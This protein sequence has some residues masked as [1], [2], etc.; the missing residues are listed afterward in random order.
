MSNGKNRR[1]LSL[2]SVRNLTLSYEKRKSPSGYES[3]SSTQNPKRSSIFQKLVT[4]RKSSR[5]ASVAGNEITK[6]S[7]EPNSLLVHKVTGRTSQL[8]LKKPTNGLSREEKTLILECIEFLDNE[9]HALEVE[10]IFRSSGSFSQMQKLRSRLKQGYKIPRSSQQNQEDAPDPL[11]VAD[12][13][14]DL[15]RNSESPLLPKET[16]QLLLS[17]EQSNT[18]L[19]LL[20]AVDEMKVNNKEV[21]EK[22]IQLLAKTSSL[23]LFNHMSSKNIATIFTPTLIRWDP[24]QPTA[25]KELQAVTEAITSII[26]DSNRG[27]SMTEQTKFK[28]RQHHSMPL[29]LQPNPFYNPPKYLFVSKRSNDDTENC[30]DIANDLRS[31]PKIKGSRRPKDIPQWKPL[32]EEERT[33]FDASFHAVDV[34]DR[35][36]I[37]ASEGIKFFSKFNLSLEQVALIWNLVDREESG[38]LGIRE[39]RVAMALCMGLNRNCQIPTKLPTVL[40][41]ELVEPHRDSQDYDP[42]ITYEKSQNNTPFSK[43]LFGNYHKT[44]QFVKKDAQ[45]IESNE[46]CLKGDNSVNSETLE[47]EERHDVQERIHSKFV[48]EPLVCDEV[49]ESI[50]WLWIEKSSV[51]NACSHITFQ[52]EMPYLDPL[53]RRKLLGRGFHE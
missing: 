30:F 38:V 46:I 26:D 45:D 3:D 7:K 28:T 22:L 6:D 33:S 20:H 49:L 21:F 9:P 4:P 50:R 44:S 51:S 25:R 12:L 37:S 24:L 41:Q 17:K 36:S 15:L 29:H 47:M 48:Q 43:D 31:V 34:N 19:S 39:W 5:R 23:S 32:S 18:E 1:R 53:A 42:L 40:E 16:G 10:G 52:Q 2:D 14:K 11:T 8:H 27:V 13:L 35:G